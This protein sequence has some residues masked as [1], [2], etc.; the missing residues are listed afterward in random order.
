MA[1]PSRVL[2]WRIPW[3]KDKTAGCSP[4]GYKESDT[5]E[6]L[7]FHSRVTCG[8]L[9]PQPGI[10]PVPPRSGSRALTTKP[11]GMSRALLYSSLFVFPTYVFSTVTG[12]VSF[13]FFFFFFLKLSLK[14]LPHTC[15]LP[16][17]VRLI[18][19]LRVSLRKCSFETEF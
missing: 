10:K 3:T 2:A 16:C 13:G 11:P 9:V 1:T 5:T 7:R 12:R 6:Q 18:V 15:H 14:L 17:E 4:W 8:I 19:M